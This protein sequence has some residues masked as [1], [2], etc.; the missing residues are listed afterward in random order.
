MAGN[1]YDFFTTW[2]VA[3][4]CEE[5][6]EVLSDGDA[7]VRW[8]P[9]VY[10]QVTTTKPGDEKGVGKVMDLYTKGWLP[11]TLRWD[12]E[13][14]KTDP[15]RGFTLRAHGDFEGTGVWSFRQDGQ[16]VEMTY[17]WRIDAE[18]PLLKALTPVLKPIFSAN[19]RWAMARG[20]ESLK[21]ELRRRHARSKEEREAI[22]APPPP[23]F[24]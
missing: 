10:L 18:K 17:D 3:G 5:V 4:T 14:V 15:P 2:R 6:Y 8:W 13:V 23:T 7:L 19:H 11:Y 21:L 1:H 22:P 16:T 24:R 12:F 20:E 9:S